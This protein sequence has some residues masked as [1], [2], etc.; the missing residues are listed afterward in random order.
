VTRSVATHGRMCRALKKRCTPLSSV[1][2][3]G[4]ELKDAE[5]MVVRL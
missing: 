2:K 3:D 5:V 4:S 1:E